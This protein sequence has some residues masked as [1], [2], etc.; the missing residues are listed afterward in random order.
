MN[1]GAAAIYAMKFHR[2]NNFKKR[3]AVLLAVSRNGSILILA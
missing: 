2:N 3:I 1:K